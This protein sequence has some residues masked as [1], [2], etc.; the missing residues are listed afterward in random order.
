MSSPYFNYLHVLKINGK[1]KLIINLCFLSYLNLINILK[2]HNKKSMKKNISIFLGLVFGLVLLS[3]C[4]ASTPTTENTTT[5]NTVAPTTNTTDTN[6]PAPVTPA[7]ETT[8]T[9]EAK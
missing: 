1:I 8:N 5:D 6:T 7:P 2:K 9:P 3:G 4:A